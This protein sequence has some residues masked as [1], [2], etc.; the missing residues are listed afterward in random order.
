MSNQTKGVLITL[1]AAAA[2]GAAAPVAKYI[3]QFQITTGCML[4][5]R[6]FI[7]ALL[8]WSY[9]LFFKKDVKYKINRHQLMT[10]IVIGGVVYF[11]T[12]TFYFSAI[13]Y[14]PVSMHIMIFYTYP[15]LV[16]LFSALV[17]KEKI[18]RGQYIAMVVAFLGLVLTI[19]FDS[20]QICGFGLLLSALAA[21][22]NG[23]YIV[24]LGLGH[25]GNVDSVVTAAYTNLFSA[26]AFFLFSGA[27]GELTFSLPLGCWIGIVFLSVVTTAVGIIALS[28][29]IRYIG[30]SK[31]SII[32]IFEP[33]EASVLSVVFLGERMGLR[34]FV[35][36]V[37]IVGAIIII[38]YM[39]MGQ[40]ILEEE[41]EEQHLP[42]E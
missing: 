11:L 5:L 19:S 4:A 12:T 35:G 29:G 26:I 16:N 34:R 30:S 40:R 20:L 7:A 2:F 31:A 6:F 36:M 14:I 25:I 41:Q 39:Q 17:F 13:K 37:L 32:S 28:K 22:C 10:M 24:L 27:R 18:R 1:I 42:I 38:N 33:L 8:L 15:F 23:S 3:Y 9:I 21:L